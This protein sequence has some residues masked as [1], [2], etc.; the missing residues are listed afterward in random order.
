[1]IITAPEK[2]PTA[3]KYFS[4]TAGIGKT[5]F[6]GGSI[7]MGK[8]ED[9]QQVTAAALDRHNRIVYNP[10]RR[11]WDSSWIQSKDNPQFREQVEWELKA[12]EISEIHIYYFH[13]DTKAPI[14]LLELGAFADSKRYKNYV[15]CPKGFYR[16]G[17]VDIFCERYGIPVFE[18][19]DEVVRILNET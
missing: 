10:R 13:P 5:I 14:T 12:Q 7:E 6:L 9:W 16:K 15:V 1:M 18:T 17:N 19:L 2:L 8:A 11:D 4:I 3:E